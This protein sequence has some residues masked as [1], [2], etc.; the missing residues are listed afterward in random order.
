MKTILIVDDE[1]DIAETLQSYL[2]LRGYRVFVAYDGREGLSQV[3]AQRP[4]LVI[5]DMMMPRMDGPSMICEILASRE[6][7][8]TPIITMSAIERQQ[9]YPFFLKP[10]DPKALVEEIRRLLREA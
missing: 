8:R 7:A 3:Q 1:P 2:E 10:F 9:E 4:D 6:V 5:T